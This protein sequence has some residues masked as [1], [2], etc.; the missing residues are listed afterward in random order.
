MFASKKPKPQGRI[1]CLIGAETKVTG[2]VVFTGG[3]RVDGEIKG[4]VHAA[5]DKPSTL[6][7]SEH[8]R[9]EGEI[10]VSHLVIN[11]TVIGPI[12]AAELLELQPKAR[13]TGD[14]EYGTIEIH[15]GAVVQGRMIHEGLAA[16]SVELKLAS[17]N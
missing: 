16:K 7:V 14:V 2:D 3:L 11:G 5:G 13:V 8:A 17:A 12:H 4:N 9:I 10:R 15:L 6:V 1:D